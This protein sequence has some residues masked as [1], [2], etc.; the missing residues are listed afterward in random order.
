M[1]D[2]VK[3]KRGRG[4]REKRGRRDSMMGSEEGENGRGKGSVGEDDSLEEREKEES[5]VCNVSIGTFGGVFEIFDEAIG[6]LDL[7]CFW[8][9]VNG[10]KK[11][12]RK[13]EERKE[14]LFFC[15]KFSVCSQSIST[16]S[17]KKAPS[18]QTF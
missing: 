8:G 15:H 4:G 7:F 6:A 12:R 13:G 5:V 10:E 9:C 2:E 11:R 17:S 14:D 3:K 16:S 18:H 1:C